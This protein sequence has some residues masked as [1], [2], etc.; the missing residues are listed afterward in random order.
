MRE[1]IQQLREDA[2]RLRQQL[3]DALLDFLS[4]LQEGA[5]MTWES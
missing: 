5:I 2:E 4:I 1:E 3:D